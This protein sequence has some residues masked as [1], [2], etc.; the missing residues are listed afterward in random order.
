MNEKVISTLDNLLISS[1]KGNQKLNLKGISLYIEA[2]LNEK[3]EEEKFVKKMTKEKL[4]IDKNDKTLLLH[5]EIIKGDLNSFKNL[6]S[7]FQKDLKHK[8]NLDEDFVEKENKRRLIHTAAKYNKTDIID[9]LISSGSSPS[10]L[11]KIE[12]TPVFYAAANGSADAIII[13]ISKGADPNIKDAF[14]NLPLHVKI[15][16]NLKVGY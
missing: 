2:S 8:L 14:E 5:Y 11:D 4:E 13:L 15:L 10:I 9:F 3:K 12:A 6:L 1:K 16:F 7:E